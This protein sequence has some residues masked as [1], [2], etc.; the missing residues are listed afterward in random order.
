[1]ARRTVTNELT[2]E[3]FVFD[4]N[5]NEPDGRIRRMEFTLEPNNRVPTHAHPGTAQTFEVL[6]GVLCVRAG[7]RTLKL[8]PGEHYETERGE[9]HSQ[10]NEGPDVVR[11]IEGYDPPLAIEA[12]FTAV[13]QAME[14]K[15]PF[16]MAVLFSEFGAVS[17]LTL[18][19]RVFVAIF[20]ALG[21][22]AGLGGW[23]RPLLR[24]AGLARSA[25]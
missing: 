21:R 7:G 22:L 25:R 2:G 11:A 18:G 4:D 20:G 5:W 1:M 9:F 3:T 12:L 14:S 17:R 23:Y 8:K 24:R 13:P 10:W 16:K 6:S 19:G 15:N